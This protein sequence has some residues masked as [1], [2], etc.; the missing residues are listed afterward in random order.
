L[1]LS[2]EELVKLKSTLPPRSPSTTLP[3]V[4][5]SKGK[6]KEVSLESDI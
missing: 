2:A 3:K 6:E 5:I 4:I 1:W